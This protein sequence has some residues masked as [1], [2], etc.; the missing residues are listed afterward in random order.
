MKVKRAKIPKGVQKHLDEIMDQGEVVISSLKEPWSFAK[1][2]RWSILT[3]RRIFL[4]IRWPFGISYD[5]WPLYLR[6]LSV[7]MNEGIV[8]D[9]IYLDYFGQKFQLK[10]FVKNRKK[11][12]GF[13]REVNRLIMEF[14]PTAD[15]DRS[16]GLINEIENLSKIFYHKQI[17][18]EEYER[19]KREILEKH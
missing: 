9:T 12:L 13:F 10:I 8:F 6:A 2:Y 4:I 7:D 1:W 3:D 5:V 19:R 18:Q 11:T 15:K 17:T 14:N 16:R